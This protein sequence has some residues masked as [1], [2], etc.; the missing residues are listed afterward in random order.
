MTP[1]FYIGQTPNTFNQKGRGRIENKKYNNRYICCSNTIVKCWCH[2]YTYIGCDRNFG[3]NDIKRK[4]TDA[5]RRYCDQNCI[6]TIRFC[7]HENN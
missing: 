6:T 7:G 4:S 1:A 3:I 5:Q 2:N